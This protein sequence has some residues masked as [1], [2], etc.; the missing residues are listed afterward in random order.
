MYSKI[1]DTKTANLITVSISQS[2][3]GSHF[4]SEKIAK[5]RHVLTYTEKKHNFRRIPHK[6]KQKQNRLNV[7]CTAGKVYAKS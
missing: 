7:F 6:L 2:W 1:Y 5:Y 3:Y 4:S